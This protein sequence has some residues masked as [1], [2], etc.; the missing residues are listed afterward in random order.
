MSYE[1]YD[2]YALLSKLFIIPVIFLVSQRNVCFCIH[3]KYTI[4][5]N[6]MLQIT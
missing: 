2:L 4:T 6:T 5:A 1:V 3:C